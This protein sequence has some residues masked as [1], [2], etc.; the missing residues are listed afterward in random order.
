MPTLADIAGYFGGEV[1]GDGAVIID[2]VGSLAGAGGRQIAFYESDSHRAAL[3]RCRAG[4]LLVSAAHAE[5]GN[6]P[7]WVVAGAPRLYFARLAQWL[8]GKK[9][10]AGEISPLA[11]V[12]KDAQVGKGVS[13]APFAV[14]EAGAVLGD[15]CSVGAG[16][17]VGAGA[18]IGAATAV[19][20]RAAVYAGTVVGR[21]CV[22]H[23]GAVLGADGF[24]FV[25][26]ENGAQIKIPQLGG[27]R[28]GDDVEVGANSAI[29]RGALDD[30]VICGGVKIDNLVQIGHNVHVGE[31]TVICGG[32]GIAGSV[33]IGAGCVIGGKAG[34]AGHLTIGDG[35]AVAGGSLV[36]RDV[37]AGGTVSSVLPAAPARE[38]RRFAAGLRRLARRRK[39][40]AGK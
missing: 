18:K 38:W 36:T 39:N 35:A 11:F 31:N 33:R 3:R 30:T 25:R 20:A 34:I 29:D 26:D 24:G 28:L 1:R 13:V 17:T 10:A 6:C 15:G 9:P 7:R 32:A 5:V 4:A 27:L 40:G 16:A 21:R 2:G 12:A 37:A 8:E 22:I 23:G 19:M 14:V